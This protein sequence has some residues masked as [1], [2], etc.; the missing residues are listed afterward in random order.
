VTTDPPRH[1][2]EWDRDCPLFR[3]VLGDYYCACRLDVPALKWLPWGC[4]R[5]CTAREKALATLDPERWD[6]VT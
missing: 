3:R 4:P 2:P 5:D 1:P 6:H